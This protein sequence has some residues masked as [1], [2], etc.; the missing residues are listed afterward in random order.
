MPRG[1]RRLLRISVWLSSLVS[2]RD[3]VSQ[4]TLAVQFLGRSMSPILVRDPAVDLA[5]ISRKAA[6]QLLL[7]RGCR[8]THHHWVSP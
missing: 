6:V 7:D 5:P 2:V 3:L 1:V 8:S 4:K